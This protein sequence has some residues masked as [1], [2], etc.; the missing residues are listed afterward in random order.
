MEST[1]DCPLAV[2]VHTEVISELPQGHTNPKG[3]EN[4]LKLLFLHL[5]CFFHGL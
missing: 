4:S 1:R 2:P 3:Q 5:L